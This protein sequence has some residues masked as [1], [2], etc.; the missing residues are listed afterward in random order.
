MSVI[1]FSSFPVTPNKVLIPPLTKSNVALMSSP[2]AV[3]LKSKLITVFLSLGSV[4]LAVIVVESPSV[5]SAAEIEVV[6]LI[7]SFTSKVLVKSLVDELVNSNELISVSNPS[8]FKSSTNSTLYLSS[9]CPAGMTNCLVS[10]EMGY[11]S[12]V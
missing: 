9:F 11:L 12:L 5:R 1:R 3:P 6:I 2:S 4:I 8:N 10:V 7:S